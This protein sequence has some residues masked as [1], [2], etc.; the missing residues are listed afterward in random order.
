MYKTSIYFSCS[1][2][3]KHLNDQ[4]TRG[5]DVR[6][7]IEQAQVPNTYG[8]DTDNEDNITNNKGGNQ[9]NLPTKPIDPLI[10]FKIPKKSTNAK[11]P[12]EK[13]DDDKEKSKKQRKA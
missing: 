2:I 11:R 6:P 3:E 4:C 10:D 1:L 9:P 8:V 7:P 13:N 12:A 5:I